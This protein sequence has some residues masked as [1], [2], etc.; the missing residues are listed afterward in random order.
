MQTTVNPARFMGQEMTLAPL[1]RGQSVVVLAGFR[2]GRVSHVMAPNGH[3]VWLW[4]LT[5]PHCSAALDGLC[6][7]GETKTL[8]LAKQQ[9]RAAFDQWLL[10]ALGQD[11]PVLWH[12]TEAPPASK[13]LTSVEVRPV[14]KS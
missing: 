6:L 11:G 4:S 9:L 7:G 12:W 5:G 10:W 8:G 1:A 2:I 13:P 14:G 3:S